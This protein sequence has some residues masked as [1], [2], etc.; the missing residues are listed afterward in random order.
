MRVDV[1]HSLGRNIAG[2]GERLSHGACTTLAVRRRSGD[3][4]GVAGNAIAH[5][6][7]DDVAPRA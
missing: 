2:I 7:G 3:V 5:D 1:T 4:M 6:L